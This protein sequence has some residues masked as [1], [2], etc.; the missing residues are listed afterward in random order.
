MCCCFLNEAEGNADEITAGMGIV[1]E[2]ANFRGSKTD[3][4]WRK[5]IVHGGKRNQGSKQTKT[6][7]PNTRET[8]SMITL[9]YRPFLSLNCEYS[10]CC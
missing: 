5:T 3:F 7:S 9:G 6:G 1:R 4:P 10:H 8:Q 2:N